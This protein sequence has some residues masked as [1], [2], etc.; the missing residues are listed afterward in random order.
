[1]AENDAG[2]VYEASP[3]AADKRVVEIVRPAPV[4][5]SGSVPPKTWRLQSSRFLSAAEA[6]QA[7]KLHGDMPPEQQAIKLSAPEVRCAIFD[8]VSWFP[9]VLQQLWTDVSV[10]CPHAERYNVSASNPAVVAVAGEAEKRKRDGTAVRSLVFETCGHRVTA[11]L[12]GNGGGEWSVQ[13]AC[14]R[15]MED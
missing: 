7:V 12:G 10:R 6:V 11:R 2:T 9:G 3:W 1:M 14:C 4:Q 13:P 5:T 15:K 8:V